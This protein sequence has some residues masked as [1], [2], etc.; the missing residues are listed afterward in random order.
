ML[1]S[2]RQIKE[3]CDLKGST[4]RNFVNKHCLSPI[5]K[6]DDSMSCL[7]EVKQFLDVINSSGWEVN[8]GEQQDFEPLK[9]FYNLNL[10]Q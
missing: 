3:I 1:K 6:K 7:Y 9:S 8:D 5:E 10:K 2:L 4:V